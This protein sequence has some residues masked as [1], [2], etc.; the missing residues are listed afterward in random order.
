MQ[1]LLFM[2]DGDCVIA[3][4]VCD[5]FIADDDTPLDLLVQEGSYAAMLQR[6]THLFPP[7]IMASSRS[8]C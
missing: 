2:G 7:L 5:D 8:A 1:R 6:V 3:A 4:L